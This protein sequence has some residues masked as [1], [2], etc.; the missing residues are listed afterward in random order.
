MSNKSIQVTGWIIL[1]AGLA[2][3]IHSQFME[4][5]VMS[6]YGSPD[7][8]GI[9]AAPQKISNIGLIADK[10]NFT[11]LGGI[12]LIVGLQFALVPDET[13]SEKK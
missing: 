4:T 3:L 9:S 2:L 8:Y 13:K 6:D 1:M 12:L 7:A 10:L 11:I 5:S